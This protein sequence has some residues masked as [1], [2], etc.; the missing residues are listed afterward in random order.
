M[1]AG[2]ELDSRVAYTALV[3]IV[4]IL[5]LA[6]LRI[7]ARN[8]AA[9]EARGAVEVGAGHYPWVVMVH[10]SWLVGCVL[11]VWLLDRPWIAGLG[12]PML[13]LFAAGMGL[14][15]WTIRT[16]GGRWSTRVVVLPGEPLVTTGPFRWLRHPNYLG[17]VL[18]LAALPLVH[19]AW[20]TAVA[21]SVLN[22]MLLR[23]RIRVEDAALSKWSGVPGR[24][25]D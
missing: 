9:L 10:A 25:G 17:V 7:S 19:G 23:A 14:R 21:F 24:A 20:I 8:V 3:A 11:E 12:L 5:R 2:V 18:E 6:E 16:L 13:A 15:L 22:G 4:A 1:M